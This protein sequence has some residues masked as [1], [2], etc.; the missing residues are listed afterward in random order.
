MFGNV[1][2]A[3][4]QTLIDKSPESLMVRV[5]NDGSC[6]WWPM[7]LYS[8]SRCPIDVT[9]FPFDKQICEVNYESYTL[10]TNHM[11]IT[12]KQ[13]QAHEYKDT[14]EWELLGMYTLTPYAEKY[15]KDS[16]TS[17]FAEYFRRCRSVK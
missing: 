11:N 13:F 9:W 2:S 1:D 5:H 4:R 17:Y 10:S 7:F 8:E 14:G 16:P 12:A 15:S 6:A 3:R